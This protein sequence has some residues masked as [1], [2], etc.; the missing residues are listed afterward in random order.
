MVMLSQNYGP[1]KFLQDLMETIILDLRWVRLS[2]PQSSAL[3]FEKNVFIR[4]G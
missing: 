2:H 1:F 3:S 4:N